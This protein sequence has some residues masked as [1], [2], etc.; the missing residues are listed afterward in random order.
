MERILLHVDM[1]AFYASV[2]TLERPEL[3]NV[4]LVI[5]AD[6]KGGRS[7]GVVS[8]CNYAARK[9]GIHSGMPISKAFE[10]CPEAVFLT[11][12]FKKY[13][14]ASQE[15][16]EAL[17]GYANILEVVGLDEAYLD[18]TEKVAG[19]WDR[20]PS[21][22]RSLQAAVKRTTGLAC[23]V[24]AAPTKSAAKVASDYQKPH[25]STVVA[26]KQLRA[27]LDSL[28]VR[29][30]NGCGPKMTAALAENGYRTVG[31]V[32]RADSEYIAGRYGKHGAW[33]WNV[34]NG[35][36]PRTVHS[37]RGPSKSRSNERTYPRDERRPSEVLKSASGLLADLVD[38]ER[39]RRAFATISVKLRYH[40][41]TTLTRAHTLSIPLAPGAPETLAIAQATVERL[42]APLL[43]G[44]AVRMVGVRLSGFTDAPGQ[45]SLDTFC[46]HSKL[47]VPKWTPKSSHQSNKLAMSSTTRVSGNGTA[48]VPRT[49]ALPSQSPSGTGIF[50]APFKSSA[51]A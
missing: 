8:T 6:P 20:V 3:A 31:D 16:M 42:L 23:S 36:D 26:P 7:R 30:I 37:S 39:G 25:G 24:G 43:D 27:F 46:N 51:V 45:W 38:P 19:E 50:T 35:N 28:P 32:A 10:A 22:C 40:D 5:G 17:R 21:Y 34:A 14:P 44:R 4:P 29:L 13:K 9:Y 15:V 11:P 12:N 33:I 47:A 1:D 18:I 49:V 48:N 2:E 41:F